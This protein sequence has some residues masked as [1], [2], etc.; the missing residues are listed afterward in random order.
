MKTHATPEPKF[1]CLTQARATRDRLAGMLCDDLEQIEDSKK[2]KSVTESI[3]N[4]EEGWSASLTHWGQKLKDQLNGISPDHLDY[5][6]SLRECIAWI[7]AEERRQ[8]AAAN[9]K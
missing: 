7:Y 5:I 1:T 6:T 2:A 8:V 4:A 3:C 9:A